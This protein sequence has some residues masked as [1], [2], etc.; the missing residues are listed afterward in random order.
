[1]TLEQ[2][3]ERAQGMSDPHRL[4]DFEDV[5]DLWF[6]VGALAQHLLEQDPRYVMRNLARA[7]CKPPSDPHVPVARDTSDASESFCSLGVPFRGSRG[8]K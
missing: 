5:R 2:I 8:G 1:M 7:E 3:I 4:P 6:A